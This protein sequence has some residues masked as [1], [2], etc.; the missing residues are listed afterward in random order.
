MADSTSDASLATALLMRADH[1]VAAIDWCE[2][3][4]VVTPSIAEFY[5]SL[6]SLLLCV[7]GIAITLRVRRARTRALPLDAAGPII[8]AL[9]V[10]SAVFHATLSLPWQRAD[11]VAENVGV[12]ALLHSALRA[13]AGSS[14]AR[15]TAGDV[16]FTLHAL[17]AAAGVVGVSFFLFAELHLVG[18]SIAATR[19]SNAAAPAHPAA[20]AA[21]HAHLRVAVIS[22]LCG[23]AAWLVDRLACSTVLAMPI[24]LQL[25]AWWHV[26][27]AVA[28]HEGFAA[29][30]VALDAAVGKE[31]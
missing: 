20:N 16:S 19:A 13:G 27:C 3:N 12:T 31:V 25:H 30:C 4:Y 1:G 5:N 21:F 24:H 15:R 10:A 8:F 22:I 17:V 26:A 14:S 2:R 18:V 9:G 23:G 28:L 29:A 11:E 7:A 6:S